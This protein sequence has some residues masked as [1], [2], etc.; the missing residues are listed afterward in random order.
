MDLTHVNDTEITYRAATDGDRTY[1]K[2][3]YFLAYV[4]G[5]EFAELDAGFETDLPHYLEEWSADHDGAII[6][7]SNLGVPAGGAWLRFF[8]GATQ[9]DAYMA[10]RKDPDNPEERATEHDPRTIPE[11]CIAVERRYAGRKVG[12]ELLRRAC[13]LAK[14][15][16]APAI[17]LWVD[18]DNPRARRLYE[19]EGFEDIDVPGHVDEPTMIK[20][21]R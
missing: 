1:L 13:D 20:R 8:R 18:P 21:L 4:F 3:L 6:A 16:G 15:Q 12:Q 11:V 5:D 2:R 19:R 7:E 17:A 9:G 10:N 14:E